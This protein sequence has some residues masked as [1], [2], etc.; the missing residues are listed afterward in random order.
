MAGSREVGRSGEGPGEFRWANQVGVVPG[1]SLLVFDALLAR[2]TIFDESYSV[3]G[4]FRAD[5]PLVQ[6]FVPFNARD[7]VVFSKSSDTSAAVLHHIVD[8]RTVRSFGPPSDGSEAS[9][10]LRLG[11]SSRGRLWVVP[12]N[13]YEVE[14]WDTAGAV[15][16]RYRGDRAWFGERS[17]SVSFTREPPNTSLDAVWEDSDGLLWLLFSTAAADWKAGEIQRGR[18]S[19]NVWADKFYDS[20]VEVVDPR[21]GELIAAQSFGNML[22]AVAMTT[23]GLVAFEQETESGWVA[24]RVGELALKRPGKGETIPLFH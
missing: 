8:G 9:F 22:V 14:L 4:V 18:S 17:T 3:A 15:L 11:H 1:D 24:V 5:D 23:P 10:P 19:V 2:F 6:G 13:K 7:L 16:R 21:T 20:R 12:R